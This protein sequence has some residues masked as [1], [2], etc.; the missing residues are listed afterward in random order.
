MCGP[1]AVRSAAKRWHDGIIPQL[2]SCGGVAV[3][4]HG[5][6]RMLPLQEY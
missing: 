2:W 4:Q 6:R 3:G 5:T 1:Y